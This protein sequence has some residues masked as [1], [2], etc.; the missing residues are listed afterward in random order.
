MLTGWERK[1]VSVGSDSTWSLGPK[2]QGMLSHP[3][4]IR[5]ILLHGE[6]YNFSTI[7]PRWLLV[8]RHM[9]PDPPMADLVH[10]LLW[11]GNLVP[12]IQRQLVVEPVAH[13]SI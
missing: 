1:S 6:S 13:R 9:H 5:M 12:E 10:P 7:C 3:G 11:S 4:T 8:G 2:N